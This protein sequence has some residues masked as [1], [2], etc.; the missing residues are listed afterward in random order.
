MLKL[1][2]TS[3]DA[4]KIHTQSEGLEKMLQCLRVKGWM[5]S[6]QIF[7]LISIPTFAY[8]S[9][10]LCIDFFLPYNSNTLADDKINKS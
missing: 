6:L 2:L 1:K 3:H 7:V 10:L 4:P 8:A 5:K 9:Q